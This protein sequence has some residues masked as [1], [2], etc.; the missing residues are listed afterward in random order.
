MA[1]FKVAGWDIERRPTVTFKV[2]EVVTTETG[3]KLQTRFVTVVATLQNGPQG[4]GLYGRHPGSG[5]TLM[6][7][8]VYKSPSVVKAEEKARQKK[9]A[10]HGGGGR[11]R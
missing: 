11:R 1:T 7:V 6:L 9:A 2:R 8:A 4:Y 5:R 3:A 10:P